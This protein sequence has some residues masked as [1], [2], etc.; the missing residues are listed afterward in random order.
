MGQR[1]RREFFKA[2]PVTALSAGLL[3]AV[4]S[5]SI[6]SE[7]PDGA[8]RKAGR[9][10]FGLNTS[11]VRGHNLSLAQEVDLAAKAGYNGLEPWV[12]E[13]EKYQASGGSLDDL[14]KRI[15][16]AGLRVDS[17]I[18]FFDWIVDDENR[19]RDALESAKRSMELV[20]RIGGIRIAAPPAGATQVSGLDLRRIA[21]R[22]R[23]LLEV[24][25]AI[26]VV[27][28]VEVWGFSK[29]LGRLSEAAFVAIEAGHPKA[30]IL[31][32]IY[33][34]YRGGSDFSGIPLLGPAAIHVF[35][36]NDYPAQPERTKLNDADRVFPG[37][38]VAPLRSI[39]ADLRSGSFDVMLSLELFNRKY[40]EREPLSVLEEG[41]RKMKAVASV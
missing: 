28:Q 33:H 4:P 18:G 23:K 21:E 38:G 40:W 29:T 3:T 24:G 8:N 39:L 30:C 5:S 10:T 9:F 37:D 34:L 35:H 7:A 11:T 32:D 14:R 22:Y 19:R 6:A 13:I 41:L 16:D 1:T 12:S 25:D 36:M 17:T 27:P 26:G 15:A 2:G 31:P 20:R